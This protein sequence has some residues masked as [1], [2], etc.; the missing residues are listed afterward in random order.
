M[1]YYNKDQEIF[2][3]ISPYSSGN[4]IKFSISTGYIKKKKKKKK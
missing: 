4:Q 1:L 3:K 2:F